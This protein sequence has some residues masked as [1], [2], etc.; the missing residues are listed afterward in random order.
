MASRDHYKNAGNPTGDAGRELL[1]A[2]NAGTHER[3]AGWSL[4]LL[5]QATQQ[6]PVKKPLASVLDVGCGGGANLA[7]LVNL[8]DASQAYGLDHSPISVEKSKATNA[9]AVADGRCQVVEGDVAALPYD[10]ATI[11]VATAFETIY[12]WPDV[13]AG[14]SEILRVLTPGGLFMVCNE[15]DGSGMDQLRW[16]DLSQAAD[17]LTIYSEQQLRDFFTNAG[18]VNIQVCCHPKEDWIVMFGQKPVVK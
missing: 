9:Q 10:N 12:F 8:V 18:F 16:S 14:L 7:R 3:L 17:L 15:T 5:E 6:A 2:M 4:P 11:N 13:A 1:D